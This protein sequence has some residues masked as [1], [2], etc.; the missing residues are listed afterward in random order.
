MH[1]Y[2]LIALLTSLIVSTPSLPRDATTIY[3]ILSRDNHHHHNLDPTTSTA[4]Q[5]IQDQ[6][7]ASSSNDDITSKSWDNIADAKKAIKTWILDR[8]E[9][10]AL[11]TTM[12]RSVFSQTVS[13]R[14]ATS[15]FGLQR[16]TMGS[17]VLLPIL[18]IIVLLRYIVDLRNGTPHGILQAELNETWLLTTILS[19]RRYVSELG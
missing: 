7:T 1:R 2:V 14:A 9:T 19:Q 10:W 3:F 16:G 13:L 4:M 17:M 8:H 11:V 12:I 18:L 5:S 15:I 6:W